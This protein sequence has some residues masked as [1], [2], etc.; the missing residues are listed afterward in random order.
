MNFKNN[1]IESKNKLRKGKLKI[2]KKRK[3]FNK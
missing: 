2:V 1:Y 3:K